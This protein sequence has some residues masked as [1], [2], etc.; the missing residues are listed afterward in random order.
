MVYTI[1]QD[2]K[3]DWSGGAWSDMMTV[4]TA[5]GKD[6]ESLHRLVGRNLK[7]NFVLQLTVDVYYLRC[8]DLKIGVVDERGISYCFALKQNLILW[9]CSSV[10]N[11]VIVCQYCRRLYG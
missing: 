1:I 6:L 7:I 5:D 2:D 11:S 4:L 8:A 10:T 9:S 3:M